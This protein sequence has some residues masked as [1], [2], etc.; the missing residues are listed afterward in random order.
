MSSKYNQI[1]R[2][3]GASRRRS[4]SVKRRSS[5]RSSSPRKTSRRK[6][7]RRATSRRVTSRRS[8]SRRVSSKKLSRF[9]RSLNWVKKHKK[10]IGTAV[11][12]G[13]LATAVARSK[14]R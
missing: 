3:S 5:S 7:S 12:V 2:M 6:T 1:G 10:A 14:R 13:T 4:A 11:V 9:H 8:A